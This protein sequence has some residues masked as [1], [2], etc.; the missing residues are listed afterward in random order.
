MHNEYCSNFDLIGLAVGAM[1]LILI[2][3]AGFAYVGTRF[4]EEIKRQQNH[5]KPE[6]KAPINR[7]CF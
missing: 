7:R 1:F 5:E 3:V 6:E 2:V 4:E